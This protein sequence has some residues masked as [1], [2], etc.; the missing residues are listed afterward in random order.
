MLIFKKEK[1]VVKLAERYVEVMDHCFEAARIS[2]KL[3]LA[4]S[5]PDLEEERMKVRRLESQADNLLREIRDTLY[6]GAYVPLIREDIYNVFSALDLTVNATEALCDF[7]VNER[8]QVPDEFKDA[9]HEILKA[10]FRTAK[11]LRRAVLS[12]FEPKGKMDSVREHVQEVK[13]TESEVDRLAS[14]LTREIFSREDL[15][16]SHRMHLK[17]FLDEFG[18]ITDRAEDAG[19]QL[20]LAALKSVI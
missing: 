16:L 5:T 2:L 14:V 11:P 15:R 18:D 8:P 7:A 12:Y 19:D 20:E 10:T 13:Q 1:K 4:D 17:H 6:S 9:F 3:Y